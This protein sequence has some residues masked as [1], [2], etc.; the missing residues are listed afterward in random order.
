MQKIHTSKLSGAQRA[1]RFDCLRS[2]L[3]SSEIFRFLCLALL[4]LEEANFKWQDLC[5]LAWLVRNMSAVPSH[6]KFNSTGRAP[7]SLNSLAFSR[8]VWLY[9]NTIAVIFRPISLPLGQKIIAESKMAD[10]TNFLP[11]SQKPLKSIF[12]I[13][14]LN[15]LCLLIL[16]G[17]RITKIKNFGRK[18]VPRL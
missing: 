5:H 18:W 11:V 1:C 12:P 8:K 10:M 16:F 2:M 14:L 3:P 13:F 6:P 7:I 4:S 9:R 17:P 15:F